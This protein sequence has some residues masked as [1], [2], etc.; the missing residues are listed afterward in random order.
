MKGFAFL[1]LNL[2][3][4]KRNYTV[5]NGLLLKQTPSLFGMPLLSSY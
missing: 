3:V 4:A 1:R 5:G 2:K